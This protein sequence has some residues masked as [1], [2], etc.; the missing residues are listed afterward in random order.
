M[1]EIYTTMSQSD[2]ATTAWEAARNLKPLNS[3]FR[4]Q[5]LIKLGEYY[6]KTADWGRAISAYDDLSRNAPSKDVA[7]SAAARADLLRK[8]HKDAAVPNN[9]GGAPSATAPDDSNPGTQI[10]PSDN[11][12]PAP[13]KGKKKKASKPASDQ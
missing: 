8:E 3:P 2:Q 1:G 7:R 11:P 13:K 10:E 4:L 5:S 12:A 6:E 9:S